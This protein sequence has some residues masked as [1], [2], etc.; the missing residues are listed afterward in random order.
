M[1]HVRLASVSF[2]TDAKWLHIVSEHVVNTHLLFLHV[3]VFDDD[4]D[5]EVER[6]ERTEDDEED[7]VEVH[8]V[9]NFTSVL[10]VLLYSTSTRN[11]TLGSASN[12]I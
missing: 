11:L 6:E 1:S 3:E 12:N 4:T 7:E 9:S 8:P 10:L 5:E 2:Q